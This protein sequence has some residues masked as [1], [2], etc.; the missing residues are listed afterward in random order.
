MRE[1][2]RPIFVITCPYYTSI[3]KHLDKKGICSS[4]IIFSQA[5]MIDDLED[6][7][8]DHAEE[9]ENFYNNLGDSRSKKILER[10]TLG[11]KERDIYELAMLKS[12]IQYFPADIFDFREEVLLDGGAYIGDTIEEFQKVCAACGAKI[13][14][15]YAFE[16]DKKNYEKLVENPKIVIDMDAIPAGLSNANE[17]LS[18]HGGEG[19][20][21]MIDEEGETCTKVIAVDSMHMEMVP[22][23]VKMDIEGYELAALQG[24]KE[25]IKTHKPKLAI[26]IY[27]KQSDIWEIPGYIKSLVPEYRFYIRNYTNWLDEIVLYGVV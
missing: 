13:K 16:P 11:R 9:I 22:T 6:C 7:V 17:N 14:K 27:H 25:L 23:I 1:F 21:S 20:S 5:L 2:E 26:C 15:V 10:M 19:G 24:M 4:D 8:R 18:F 3:L 12:D